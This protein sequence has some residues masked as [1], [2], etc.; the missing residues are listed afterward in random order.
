M[1]VGLVEDTVGVELCGALKNI[2][3]IGA[4]FSDGLGFGGN[5]KVSRLFFFVSTTKSVTT[6]GFYSQHSLVDLLGQAA[7]MR[8]GLKEMVKFCKTFYDG[9]Q[10]DTFLESCGVADLITTCYGLLCNWTSSCLDVVFRNKC[11]FVTDVVG[12]GLLLLPSLLLLMLK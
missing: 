4:G 8:I 1:N 10:D 7:L 11:R 5:T 3:A 12:C 2:V 6:N 9:I